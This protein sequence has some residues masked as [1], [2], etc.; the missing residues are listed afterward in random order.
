MPEPPLN[1]AALLSAITAKSRDITL[2]TIVDESIQME[3]GRDAPINSFQPPEESFSEKDIADNV[4][5]QGVGIPQDPSFQ[6]LLNF[7]DGAIDFE[8]DNDQIEPNL[9]APAPDDLFLPDEPINVAPR[10]IL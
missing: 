9:E 7:G 6:N 3:I 1:P 2:S 4:S 8:F 10:N 5:E